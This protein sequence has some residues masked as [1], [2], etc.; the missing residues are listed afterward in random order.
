VGD[1]ISDDTEY[2]CFNIADDEESA[3][4]WGGDYHYE[5]FESAACVLLSGLRDDSISTSL[6]HCHHGA[7]RSVAVCAAAMGCHYGKTYKQC[8]NMIK[9]VRGVANPNHIMEGHAKRFI[10]ENS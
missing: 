3:E 9:K 7:N 4:N 2:Y 8:Y 1:N 6:I 5:A 10:K